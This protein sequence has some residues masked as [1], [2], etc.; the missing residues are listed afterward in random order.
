MSCCGW[1]SS[2]LL[3]DTAVSVLR[4]ATFRANF[5]ERFRIH[6]NLLALI[7]V[8][9][10]CKVRAKSQVNLEPIRIC[11][12]CLMTG[13][14]YRLRILLLYVSASQTAESLEK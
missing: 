5:Y 12:I 7:D 3:R 10:P 14:S 13:S 8:Q 9:F 11:R 6:L 4:T 2:E 1:H